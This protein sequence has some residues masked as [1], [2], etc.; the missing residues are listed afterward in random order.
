M[1]TK[2]K[3][4]LLQRGYTHAF[5]DAAISTVSYADRAKFLSHA[6][7]HTAADTKGT[8]FVVPYA[9]G[10]PAMQLQQLLHHL[11][12]TSRCSPAHRQA[13]CFVY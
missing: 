13:F 2:F 7:Q 9:S 4:R 3:H 12:V 1:V 10:L 11:H 6:Q 5:I 8:A